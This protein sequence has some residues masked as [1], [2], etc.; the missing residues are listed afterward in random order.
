MTTEEQAPQP[1]V[2]RVRWDWL[3]GF[4]VVYVAV[5]RWLGVGGAGLL[6]VLNLVG[7]LYTNALRTRGPFWPRK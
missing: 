6:L 5:E 7:V 2:K 3:L 1:F 4:L